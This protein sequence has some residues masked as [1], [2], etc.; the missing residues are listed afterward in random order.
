MES[1]LSNNGILQSTT[2]VVN[3]PLLPPIQHG[4]L[5]FLLDKIV[6]PSPKVNIC[7]DG[8]TFTSDDRPTGRAFIYALSQFSPHT[9]LLHPE[10]SIARPFY[11]STNC[12]IVP[13][14]TLLVHPMNILKDGNVA[15][16]SLDSSLTLSYILS[17]SGQ[18]LAQCVI[19]LHILHVEVCPSFVS[20]F[21]LSFGYLP[22]FV[23]S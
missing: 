9:V 19:A 17:F 10:S 1:L 8:N 3:V 12:A 6:L 13:S 7:S 20:G 5:I 16:S 11:S 15:L 23:L 18:Y 14:L 4:I 2:S 21:S 22:P